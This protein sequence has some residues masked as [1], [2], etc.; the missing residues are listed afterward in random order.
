MIWVINIVWY[1]LIVKRF[2]NDHSVIIN[3]CVAKFSYTNSRI[4]QRPVWGGDSR[5]LKEH[6]SRWGSQ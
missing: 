4:E 5:G 1:L 2:G 6:C 3:T